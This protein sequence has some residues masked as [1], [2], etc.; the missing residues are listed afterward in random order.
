MWSQVILPN[1][2]RSRRY[3]TSKAA[4]QTAPARLPLCRA[5]HRCPPLAPRLLSAREPRSRDAC[6]SG[7]CP[8]GR[9]CSQRRAACVLCLCT[10]AGGT[11]LHCSAHAL[12]WILAGGATCAQSPE[13]CQTGMPFWACQLP[14]IRPT[15]SSLPRGPRTVR[16]QWVGA[17]GAGTCSW[18]PG[19]GAPPVPALGARTEVSVLCTGKRT[20]PGLF[21]VPPPP[22]RHQQSLPAFSHANASFLSRTDVRAEYIH[23]TASV[24]CG[25]L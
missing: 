23:S 25:F 5:A 2:T 9:W 8:H 16:A 18:L 3:S 15:V 11:C 4:R 13:P 10:S 17:D 20:C 7:S 6:G 14:I 24:R 22:A 19:G 21:R 12:A 1:P